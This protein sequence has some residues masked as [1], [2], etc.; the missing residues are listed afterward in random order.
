MHT[1]N[2]HMHTGNPCMYMGIE[3]QNFAYGDSLFA[4]WHCVHMVINI[5]T[6][7]SMLHHHAFDFSSQLP[8]TLVTVAITLAALAII[9]PSSLLATI[10][11][12]AIALA[13]LAVESYKLPL[14][15]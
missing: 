4:Y 5:H 12:V 13:A 11:A 10:V 14:S 8:T 2:P 3:S 6:Y 15:Q 9:L 1:G 7:S